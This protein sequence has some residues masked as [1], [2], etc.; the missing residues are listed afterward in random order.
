MF[1][2]EDIYDERLID[3]TYGLVLAGGG[4]KGAYQVGVY[5]A[6]QECG[7]SERIRGIAGSSVGALN[8]LIFAQ[9]AGNLGELIWKDIHPSKFIPVSEGLDGLFD[10]K[11]GVFGRD[12]LREIMHLHVDFSQ[13]IHSDIPLYT[14]VSRY[15]AYGMGTPIAEYIR[16]NGKTKQEIEQIV[17][18]SSA[19]PTIYEPVK[20]GD[21]I[22]RDG[23]V[24]DN[25]PI[26]PLYQVGIRK[27]IVIPL[28]M[29]TK[30]PTM[31]YP[32]AEFIVIRPSHDLGDEI[33]GTM[34]FTSRGANIRMKLGYEDAMRTLKYYNSP[35]QTLPDFQTKMKALS[36][37]AYKNIMSEQV[38][39][40]TKTMI[41]R[42][43][44]K[45]YNYIKKYD[46]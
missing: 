25:L 11:E 13:I 5:K 34:D 45:L 24:T 29:H 2:I 15:D 14:T 44:N 43:M 20:I 18:A 27:F 1:S 32:D 42:D 36:D 41:D 26:E 7:L 30:I 28:S 39:D 17:L 10:G 35:E 19:I 21:Y 23:G 22:Y 9:A 3:E 8:M 16:L 4:G 33:T 46:I 40:D 38:V 37:M 12:G 31:R 6:L